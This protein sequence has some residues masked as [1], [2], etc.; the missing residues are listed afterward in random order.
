MY[1]TG[2]DAVSTC[3]TGTGKIFKRA[4]L[5]RVIHRAAVIHLFPPEECQA[6]LAELQQAAEQKLAE[7]EKENGELTMM[8]TSITKQS[9]LYLT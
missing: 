1:Y 2:T 7:R 4:K 5:L 8:N 9:F 6:W 3:F